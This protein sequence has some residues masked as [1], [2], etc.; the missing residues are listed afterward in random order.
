M[1]SVGTVTD[2]SDDVH[3]NGETERMSSSCRVPDCCWFMLL[4]Q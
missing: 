3:D 4:P 1:R 2:V